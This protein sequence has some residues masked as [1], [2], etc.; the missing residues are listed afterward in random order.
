[1]STPKPL[2]GAWAIVVGEH[3]FLDGLRTRADARSLAAWWNT[4]IARGHR[5]SVRRATRGAAS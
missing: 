3:V 2:G 1:M 4:R 5:F